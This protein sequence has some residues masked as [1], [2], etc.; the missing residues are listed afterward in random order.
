MASFYNGFS[1]VAAIIILIIEIFLIKF[2][3]KRMNDPIT[4]ILWIKIFFHPLISDLK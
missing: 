3:I 2:V 1:T 4:D